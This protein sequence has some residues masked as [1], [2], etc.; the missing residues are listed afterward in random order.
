MGRER[1]FIAL[2]ADL[3]KSEL[4]INN[5]NDILKKL[6]SSFKIVSQIE[7]RAG[8]FIAFSSIF[9]G[10]SFQAV[11]SAP[12]ISLKAALLIRSELLQILVKKSQVDAR[13]GFGFGLISSLNKKKIEESDGVA[14][15]KAGEAL[16]KTK[17]YRRFG[18]SSQSEELNR[19][20]NRLFALVDAVVQRWTAEQAEA[21]SYWLRG[22]TQEAI[23][24]RLGI[25]QSAV[26]QRLQSAGHFG[27]EEALKSFEDT[28]MKSDAIS[29]PPKYIRQ[30]TY[31][32]PL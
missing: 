23:A 16:D 28:I 24:D 12:G 18:F 29:R 3:V 19:S 22:M 6:K 9:R 27:I 10:D 5:R 31:N 15:R 17:S 7:N 21:M 26:Q 4:F 1:H 32:E 30:R 13:I 25:T 20:I 2:T 11:V 8:E 14:F